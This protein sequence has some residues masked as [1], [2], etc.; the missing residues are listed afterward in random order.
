M[1]RKERLW[2]VLV[3][4]RNRSRAGDRDTSD[5]NSRAMFTQDCG[6]LT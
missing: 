6:S 5:R 3:A 1:G 2:S 4:L